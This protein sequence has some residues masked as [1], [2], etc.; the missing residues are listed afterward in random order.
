MSRSAPLYASILEAVGNTPIVR[1]GRISEPGCAAVLVKLEHFNPSGSHK[2]R[3]AVRMVAQAEA[4]G[5][6]RPGGSIVAA[7]CGSFAISLALVCRMKKYRLLAVIPDTVTRE[8]RDIL[9]GYGARLELIPARQ[10]IAGALAR[11]KEIS[12]A[13][14]GV[15][16]DQYEDPEN[17]RTHAVGTGVELLAQAR[18]FGA[19]PAAV[20][21][22]VGTGGTVRGVREALRSQASTAIV[23]GVTMADPEQAR[24]LSVRPSGGGETFA[25][26]E[27]E[28]SG[29][30][31]W[32][33]KQRLAREEG[34]LVGITSGANVAGALLVA[35]GFR[36]E[37]FV[38]AFCC[39]TGERY[40]SLQGGFD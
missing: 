39:D 34:L 9:S 20:V 29:E 38:Y 11:A 33:M 6:L 1:L 31:A 5:R 14:E 36:P 26:R 21:M 40:F 7:S 37:H 32:Q 18:E 4:A 2:D 23:V 15:A 19:L 24:H 22:T 27:V 3:I 30:A 8:Q 17:W 10:G 25:D 28:I 35:R 16:L 12:A 13:A